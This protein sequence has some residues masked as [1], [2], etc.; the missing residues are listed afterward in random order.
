MKKFSVA[1]LA[2]VMAFAMCACGN[3]TG[4]ESTEVEN[5]VTE[6]TYEELLEKTGLDIAAPEKAEDVTYAYIAIEGAEPIAQV[7]FTLDD[8]EYCYRAQATAATSIMTEIDADGQL[9][10]ADTLEEALKSGISIGATLSGLNYDWEACA[11]I[12]I[13][14]CDG[15]AAFNDGKAGFVAWLDVAPGILYSLGVNDNCSQDELMKM[16]EA[17]FVPMQGDVE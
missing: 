9:V 15:I 7:E 17:V 11:S 1:M 2:V 12:D 13:A 4:E 16:A 8:Q 10:A 5:P 14:H 3:K 6:C